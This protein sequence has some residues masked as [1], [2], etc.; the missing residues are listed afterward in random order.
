MAWNL[1]EG[2]AY[3]AKKDRRMAAAIEEIGLTTRE[4]AEGFFTGLVQA[5]IGQQISMKA[6]DR[7]WARLEVA[8]GEVTPERLD[9][10]E[11]SELTACGLSSRKAE[12]VLGA[13]RAIVSG[14][15]NVPALEAA[16]DETVIRELVKLRGVGRWTAEMLLIF[17]LRRQDVMS[18]DDYGLREGLKR[19]YHHQDMPKERFERYRR[20]FSPYGT[21]ASLILWE[22]AGGRAE[23]A[24]AWDKSEKPAA[25]R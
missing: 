20:R 5:I 11:P 13:A 3:L 25:R 22:V 17:S 16:D 1:E 18:Y 7:I 12:Y 21:A 19:L 9:A 2:F 14:E 4:G 15:L 6:A 8:M 23:K 24:C 10:A